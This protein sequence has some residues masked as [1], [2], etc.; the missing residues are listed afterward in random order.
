MIK[1]A[2]ITV[3]NSVFD[4]EKKDKNKDIIDEFLKKIDGEIIYYEI[5]PDDFNLI[6]EK[7]IYCADEI[8]SEIVF[9]DGGTGFSKKDV[10]PEATEKVLGK[11]IPGIPE[12]MRFV[13]FNKTKKAV[14]SR[15]IAGIRNDT[16]IINLP[17]S[18]R[19]VRE[20]L[21]AIIDIL[22]RGLNMLKG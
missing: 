13:G 4:G 1:V 17:G 15:C 8:K 9:T 16:L 2:V 6:M 11:L 12:A 20:S 10:T 18:S 7:L 19:G 21:E 14:L 3:S 5:I 22:P